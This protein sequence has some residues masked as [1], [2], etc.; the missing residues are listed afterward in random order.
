M[1][2]MLK[3]YRLRKSVKDYVLKL[4]PS[5]ARRYGSLDQYTVKQI[6]KTALHL[7]L[8]MQHIPYAIALFRH[9]ESANTISLYRIKQDLLDQLRLEIAGQF[10][11]ISDDYNAKD[12]TSIAK[13]PAWHGGHSPDFGKNYFGKTSL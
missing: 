4:G 7:Q 3:R 12:I 5:L 8:N 9:E 2:S 13:R 10:L 11:G 6:E 1:L